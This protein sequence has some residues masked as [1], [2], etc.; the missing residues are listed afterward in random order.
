MATEFNIARTFALQA[1]TAGDRELLVWCDRRLTYRQLAERSR[2]LASYLAHRGLGVHR[3]RSDGLA[4]HESGQDH[5]ALAL[6]NGSEYLEGMLGA[7]AARVAPLNVNYRYTGEELRYL[8]RDARP[9]AIVYHASLAPVL[10][11]VLPALPWVEVLLQVADESGEAL[12]PGAVDYEEALAQGDPAG[13]DTEPSPDDLYILYTGGTTGMPKGVLWRQHDIFMAAMGGRTIGTWEVMTSYEDVSARCQADRGMR[14]LIL[15]P[16]MHGAAQ[17]A[18]F[19]FL[20][21]GG[22]LVLPDNPRPG[23]PRRRVADRRAP[24]C[25]V[26]DHRGRCGVAAAARTARPAVLRPVVT[27]GGGERRCAPHPDR[28]PHDARAPAPRDDLRLGRQL[29]DR[30]PDDRGAGGTTAARPCS[31][32]VRARWSWTRTCATS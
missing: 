14:L 24:T 18:A 30:R 11:E 4:G 31:T 3:E 10:G 16:L 20:A 12:L 28:A 27:V 13:P 6:Y 15:P 2:R 23:R 5:V 9:K 19:M 26:P 32:R 22:T 25:A 1:E 21:E 29:R 8:L 17:W 7:F